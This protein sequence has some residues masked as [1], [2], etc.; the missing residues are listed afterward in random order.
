MNCQ[1]TI[2]QGTLEGKVCTTYYGKRY[3][4]FEG[5]PY[6]KPPVGKLRFRVSVTYYN[7]TTVTIY[8]IPSCRLC[9][10]VQQY[11]IAYVGNNVDCVEL[12][13]TYIS[14]NAMN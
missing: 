8:L 12:V 10:Y 2:E 7:K 14:Q 9:M 4:S 6:A 3:Y 5:I 13:S 11:C 1:V